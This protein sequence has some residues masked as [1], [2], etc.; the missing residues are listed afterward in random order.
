M[1][2]I[3]LILTLGLASS[4]SLANQSHVTQAEKLADIIILN[5]DF[6]HTYLKPESLNKITHAILQM[7]A[8]ENTHQN[9]NNIQNALKTYF[10]SEKFKQKSKKETQDTYAAFYTEK[11]LELWIEFFKSP[12]GLSFLK[13]QSFMDGI[14][15]M[16]TNIIPQAQEPSEHAKQKMNEAIMKLSG[17]N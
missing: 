11:E 17:L 9:H 10:L 14:T 7:N 13:N 15:D 4:I 3:L 1:K 6:E 8:L 5:S 16:A 2:K 12:I